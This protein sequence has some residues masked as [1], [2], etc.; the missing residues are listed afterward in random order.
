MERT[1]SLI[2]IAAILSDLATEFELATVVINHMT[3]KVDRSLDP[4]SY[5]PNTIP[6]DNLDRNSISKMECT[7]EDGTILI[8]ALGESW[9]HAISTR[10]ILSHDYTYPMSSPY[11]R[12]KF[13]LAK[14]PHKPCGVT[15][16]SILDVG[17]RDCLAPSLSSSVSAEFHSQS[18]S[19][20]QSSPLR[21]QNLDFNRDQGNAPV[22][23]ALFPPTFNSNH[24]K[25]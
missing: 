19:Q 11:A 20:S 3:T 14:C 8:P 23:T 1:R 15:F 12:R 25:E 5:H 22:G 2:G 16:Y 17:I 10:V 4:S 24:E 13:I 18:Q 7:T 6:Q 9:A 21:P